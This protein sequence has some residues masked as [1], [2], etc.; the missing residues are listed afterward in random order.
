MFSTDLLNRYCSADDRGETRADYG[1]CLYQLGREQSYLYVDLRLRPNPLSS[2]RWVR[3]DTVI[4]NI[5]DNENYYAYGL[6]RQTPYT[7]FF[8]DSWTASQYLARQKTH[9]YTDNTVARGGNYDT[10]ATCPPANG[11]TVTGADGSFKVSLALLDQFDAF[12]QGFAIR[13]VSD[14]DVG[15]AVYVPRLDVLEQLIDSNLAN[16]H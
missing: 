5:E 16:G 15:S 3:A 2:G 11:G 9:C 1:A 14:K 12:F 13:F 8:K 4:H 6:N 7:P 10:D